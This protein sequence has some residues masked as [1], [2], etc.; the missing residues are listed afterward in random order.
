MRRPGRL[1]QGRA[2]ES[3]RNV[4]RTTAA[5][6]AVQGYPAA[7]RILGARAFGMAFYGDGPAGRT[8]QRF[9]VSVCRDQDERFGR[10]VFLHSP[11]SHGRSFQGGGG[12]ELAKPLPLRMY[13]KF[14]D[15]AKLCPTLPGRDTMNRLAAVRF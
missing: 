7:R 11:T 4:G 14:L 10:P 1:G 13:E 3:P 5:R 6:R 8:N 12:T 15:H 2:A 9:L